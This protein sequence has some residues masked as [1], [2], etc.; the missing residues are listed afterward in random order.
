[1]RTDRESAIDEKRIAARVE[2]R[3]TAYLLLEM[4]GQ[5]SF[6]TDDARETFWTIV[7]D[8]ALKHAP[9]PPAKPAPR[10]LPMTDAQARAFEA[11]PIPYG[12]YEHCQVGLIFERDPDYLNWLAG[13]RDGF[14]EQLSRYLLTMNRVPNHE[15]QENQA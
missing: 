3:K 1:M 9:L 14:K 12:K 13:E 8:A 2:A 11:V 4:A 5:E 15:D 6:P 7:R 10:F